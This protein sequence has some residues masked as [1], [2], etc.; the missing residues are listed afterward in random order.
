M[1]YIFQFITFAVV[2]RHVLDQ[3]RCWFGS[4]SKRGSKMEVLSDAESPDTFLNETYLDE[5]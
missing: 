4:F 2:N 1:L 3:C 5:Q